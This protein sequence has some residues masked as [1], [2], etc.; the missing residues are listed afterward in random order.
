MIFTKNAPTQV[1]V[2]GWVLETPVI[3][4]KDATNVPSSLE[5]RAHWG[6]G[7]EMALNDA[8]EVTARLQHA[9]A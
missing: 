5:C 1:P 9:K 3:W 4:A 8:W 2:E 7:V 6:E